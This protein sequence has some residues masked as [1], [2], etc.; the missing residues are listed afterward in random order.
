MDEYTE[1]PVIS[2]G[3]RCGVRWAPWMG[4]GFTSWSPRNGN[5]NAEGPWDHWVDLAIAVLKDPLTGLVRPEVHAIAQGLPE[6][7]DLY[8][9]AARE[10][11][12]DEIRARLGPA[13]VV[14]G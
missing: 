10:L 8:S 3:K 12:D 5:D 7:L 13:D 1:V 4:D 14:A 9:G 2:A 6:P 11:T